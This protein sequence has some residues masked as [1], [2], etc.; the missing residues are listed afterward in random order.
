MWSGR[1]TTFLFSLADTTYVACAQSILAAEAA[2]PV[3]F[4]AREM[5]PQVGV[6]VNDGLNYAFLTLDHLRNAAYL[7]GGPLRCRRYDHICT[8]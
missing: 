1:H 4:S 7:S 6:N 5:I 8:Y 2:I 3:Q